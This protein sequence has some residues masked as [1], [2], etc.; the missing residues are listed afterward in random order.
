[1][2]HKDPTSYTFNDVDGEELKFRTTPFA[3]IKA[4]ELMPDVIDL[5]GQPIVQVIGS[6]SSMDDLKNMENMELEVDSL[7]GAVEALS[8]F[9]RDRGGVDWVLSLLDDTYILKPEG[10]PDKKLSNRAAFNRL[11]QADMALLAKV[12]FK[13]LAVNY[14]GSLKDKLGNEGGLLSGFLQE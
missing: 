13:V 11:F 12:V 10:E 1:M 7:T 2:S 3:A 6:A 4:Y 14:G 8:S 9:L 5:I